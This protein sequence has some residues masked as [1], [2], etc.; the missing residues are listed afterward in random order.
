MAELYLGRVCGPAGFEKLVAIKRILPRRSDQGEF[1]RMFEQ[2]A[3]TA[4]TLDHANVVKVMDFGVEDSHHYL[5]MEYLHGHDLLDVQRANVGRQPL[6][7]ALAIVI[8]VARGLHYVHERPAADG[9]PLGLV[10]RDISPSN[11]FVCFSGDVKVVDFGL[12]KATEVTMGTRS[13]ALKGKI[14]YMSPEQCRGEAIDRRTDIHALGNVLY[15]L[16][17]GRRMYSAENEFGL[18]NRVATGEFER[19]SAVSPGYSEALESILLRAVAFEPEA[20]WPTA[21]AFADALEA[22]ALERAIRVGPS[23]VAEFMER[24]FG[25]V[26]YP[27]LGPSVARRQGN[28]ED[29][30]PAL[31]PGPSPEVPSRRGMSAKVTVVAALGLGAALG[32]WLGPNLADS[33]RA[34]AQERRSEPAPVSVE[35]PAKGDAVAL[36]AEPTNEADDTDDAEEAE[37]A[38]SPADEHAAPERADPEEGDAKPQARLRKPK[39]GRSR[40][41]KASKPKASSAPAEPVTAKPA[42]SD[43]FMP[44]SKRD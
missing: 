38:S 16:T 25:V 40:R 23:T 18:L 4:A 20:R 37:D 8:A 29:L 12:A 43:I 3:R 9:R 30:E 24:V 10:H 36:V 5:V 2:E 31:E 1:I 6:D 11:V 27:S 13:G 17:T 42:H 35:T 32:V 33:S 41:R 21:R 14:G 44:P 34:P 39:R 28:G 7:V 26:D 22:F 15:G 19:P